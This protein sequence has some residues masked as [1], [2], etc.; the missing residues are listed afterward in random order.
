MEGPS[1]YSIDELL[2]HAGWLRAL[3]SALI[4][5]PTEVDD[6]VQDTW[7]AAARHPPSA[8][9]PPRAWLAR[10]ITNLAHNRR[11]STEHRIEREHRAAR[12]EALFDSGDIDREL[13]MQRALVEALGELDELSRT[14]I[15]RHFFHGVSYASLARD[16]R[17]PESTVRNRAMRAIDA[18]RAKLDR[19]FGDRRAWS[20]LL[21][22]LVRRG[23]ATGAT[24]ATT[25][26][27]ALAGVFVMSSLWKV[28]AVLALALSIAW[29]VKRGIERSA[30]SAAFL[31]RSA[32]PTDPLAMPLIEQPRS[33]ASEGARTAVAAASEP[34]A[35]LVGSSTSE[36]AFGALTAR[37]VDE[38]GAPIAEA[39]LTITDRLA[40]LGREHAPRTVASS[41]G[42]V[43]IDVHRGDRQRN[44][45]FSSSMPRDEWTIQVE[46]SAPG[47]ESRVDSPRIKSG[48]TTDLGDLMLRAAGAVH[49][50]VDA[51]SGVELPR[52]WVRVIPPDVSIDERQNVGL[53]GLYQKKV[54]ASSQV[55]SGGEYTVVGVPIG[56]CRVTTMTSSEVGWLESVSDV[57]EVRASETTEAPNLELRRNPFVIAGV[58]RDP[59]GHP[60]SGVEVE[61]RWAKTNAQGKTHWVGTSTDK[62]GRFQMDFDAARLVDVYF[63]ECMEKWGELVLHDV[64][65]GRD[66]LDVRLPDVV[67]MTLLVEDDRHIPLQH[68]TIAI[69]HVGEENT[70]HSDSRDHPDGK[71]RVLVRGDP[72]FLTVSAIGRGQQ[73]LGPFDREHHPD[74][75]VVTLTENT[76]VPHVLVTAAGQPVA[77]ARI[78]LHPLCDAG[79]KLS[80]NG[81][82]ARIGQR[83]N[84]WNELTDDDGRWTPRWID[85]NHSTSVRVVVIAAA[86]GFAPAESAPF[87]LG[88]KAPTSPIAI[89]LTHGGE[90]DGHV[91]PARNRPLAG[92]LVGIA[93][94]DGSTQV[95]RTDSSGA[96]H[97][98]SLATG[99]WYMRHCEKDF[100]N[101]SV[102]WHEA[103]GLDPSLTPFEISDGRTTHCDLD[104]SETTCTLHGQVIG[105]RGATRPCSVVL[106]ADGA[107]ASSAIIA[108]ADEQG[109]FDLEPTVLGPHRLTLS[110]SG[111]H[112]EDQRIE[113]T[114]VIQR[115]VNEWSLSLATGSLEG[116]A[117]PGAMLE[118]TWTNER[119]TKLTTHFIA[120]AQGHFHA[121]G[122]PVGTGR[123]AVV[124]PANDGRKA[125][126][127]I[128]IDGTARV[129]WN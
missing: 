75:L 77:K 17:A 118:H 7:L 97:F 90:L 13:E 38:N 114:I 105:A 10:V 22:P 4:A 23:A 83:M 3:A 79:S 66:D 49:G 26:G 6:L 107:D 106:L 61:F 1:S 9:R 56:R 64:A 16:E 108:S 103:S 70:S 45:G 73:V 54:I 82:P 104:L 128:T 87:E 36:E 42:R 43:R 72:C 120:D 84:S 8:D 44:R 62:E 29:G 119:G 52:V 112:D 122:I 53:R 48:G 5:D 100:T 20:A 27:T 32:A 69:R 94:G 60:V 129:V 46:L 47:R 58:A 95:V 40:E 18:L 102:E 92:V 127:E 74:S 113:D 109:R 57:L 80:C 68:Y 96:F 115:G 86:P 125:D 71:A 37:V 24:S 81:F 33:T 50:R 39:L 59:E 110:S 21:V 28:V 12:P 85:P 111:E 117:S 34:D 101:G 30:T 93:R 2:A 14:T 124:Q 99:H 35:P 67:W 123:I 51:A 121:E 55:S 116:D 11:R 98:D 76:P 41:D 126:V 25:S 89:A 63:T 78:A 88:A 65:P 19:K 91:I 15:V 31:Q